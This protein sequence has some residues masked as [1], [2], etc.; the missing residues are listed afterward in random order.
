MKHLIP[1]IALAIATA[2]PTFSAPLKLELASPQ[3]SGLKKGLSVSYAYP[4]D[5]KSLAQTK[6]HKKHAKAGK[7]LAGLDY[8]DT[9][10]GD[11]TLTSKQAHHVIAWISGYVKFDKAGVYDVDFLSNDGLQATV[12]GKEVAYFDGRHPC[13]PSKKVEV[14]V[15]S[16]GW[17]KL[18]A[19]YF[20]RLG[21][22]CLHMRSGIGG[23]NWMENSSFG[24]K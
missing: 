6:R 24:Y 20:Q 15:P 4:N 17:Y 21:T 12:G 18:E 5:I 10:D 22:A 13:E 16:A 1:A 11:K 7:P 14:E 9:K 3:P 2:S 23:V 19:T 8:I